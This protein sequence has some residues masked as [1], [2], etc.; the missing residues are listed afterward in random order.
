MPQTATCFAAHS[1]AFRRALGKASAAR[2]RH[3]YVADGAPPPSPSPAA[4]LT[5]S[6]SY[7]CAACGSTAAIARSSTAGT[8]PSLARI[9]MFQA[10][11]NCLGI[12][13]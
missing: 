4:A 5:M 12:A 1:M 6:N 11:R 7:A 2:L 10:T 13:M 3:L 9:A 8:K